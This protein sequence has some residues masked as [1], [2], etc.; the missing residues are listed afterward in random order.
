[1][2]LAWRVVWVF[3]TIITILVALAAL[4]LFIWFGVSVGNHLTWEPGYVLDEHRP[5][6]AWW[7]LPASSLAV[8]AATA[9]YHVLERNS[10]EWYYCPNCPCVDCERERRERAQAANVAIAAAAGAAIGSSLSND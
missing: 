1:M 4:G 2:S 6:I 7:T 9:L 3:A 10:G 8:L 5:T